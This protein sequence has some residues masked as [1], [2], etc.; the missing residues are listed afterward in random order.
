MYLILAALLVVADQASKYWAQSEFGAGGALELGLG[1]SF[2]YVRNSGAAFGIFRDVAVQLG[3]VTLDGTVLLGVL[4][5]VVS[6]GL[7]VYLATH[8]RRLPTL[9]LVALTLILAGAV[10]NMIDRFAHGY[11]IDFIHFRQGSFDFPVFN[12]ADS[13]VVIGA[14]LLFLQGIV[15]DRKSGSA[16]SKPLTDA[17]SRPLTEER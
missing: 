4:S 12:I 13:C 2:T 11:V 5:A 17:E 16:E 7:L 14:G 15:G 3:S 9:A 6:V 8:R 10:G 1:F